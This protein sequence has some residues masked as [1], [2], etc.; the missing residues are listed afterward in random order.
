MTFPQEFGIIQKRGLSGQ[1]TPQPFRTG[2]GYE[3]AESTAAFRVHTGLST[4]P[5]PADSQCGAVPGADNQIYWGSSGAPGGI[6]YV[7]QGLAANPVEKQYSREQIAY[8]FFIAVAKSV[9]SLDALDSFIQLQKRSYPLETAYDYFCQEF[10]NVLQFTFEVK[11]LLEAQGED[12][13]LEKR[14]LYTCVVAAV[15]KVYLEKYLV[16][17]AGTCLQPPEQA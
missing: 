8:L 13:S 4:A 17:I 10:E 9:L 12:A 7:K 15:Q 6:C 14:L 2:D 5:V 11:D 3:P 1:D 16:F